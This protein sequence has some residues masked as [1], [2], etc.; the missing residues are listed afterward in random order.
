M[1]FDYWLEGNLN[2]LS[3]LKRGVDHDILSENPLLSVH[4]RRVWGNGSTTD[5]N[6]GE[7]A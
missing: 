7:Q 6:Q 3:Y 4:S 1:G 5:G 2:S